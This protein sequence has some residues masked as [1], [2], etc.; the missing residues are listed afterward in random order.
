MLY[1]WILALAPPFLILYYFIKSDKFTEPSSLIIKTFLLGLLI[2]IP[3]G[4]LNYYL[5]WLPEANTGIDLSFLAGVT[6]ETL[7][8]LALYFY[9]RKKTD[10]NEPMDAIVYGTLI[11]LGFAS[12]ENIEYI[13]SGESIEESYIIGILRAFTAIPMH[14]MA[15]VIMGYYFASY[16]FLAKRKDLL[17]ALLVPMT[18]HA[19]Y[20]FLAGLSLI[21][22]FIFLVIIIRYGL[23]LHKEHRLM[24]KAKDFEEESKSV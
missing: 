8:F 19:F 23:T 16:V 10:F 18:F 11:S 3:A 1:L 14:A 4:E 6:E 17:K 22:M 7:K 12:L 13:L 2:C 20:N 21:L 24:Q 9:I 5:I 15:G